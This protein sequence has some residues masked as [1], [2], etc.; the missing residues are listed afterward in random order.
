[1]IIELLLD[2]INGKFML[3]E[4]FTPSFH[5][6]RNTL[7]QLFMA[8]PCLTKVLYHGFLAHEIFCDMFSWKIRGQEY[9]H[10]FFFFW[11]FSWARKCP[12]WD[13]H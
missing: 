8:I 5:G 4:G 7:R 11:K 2:K 6:P 13:L 1:M 3:N 9:G 12:S 10:E